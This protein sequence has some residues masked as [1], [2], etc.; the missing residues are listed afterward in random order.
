M[1]RIVFTAL[2]STAIFGNTEA[3]VMSRMLFTGS[4]ADRI[5]LQHRDVTRDAR[6]CG[7]P[8]LEQER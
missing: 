6:G 4:A 5:D 1:K 3:P 8:L 7:W 2:S